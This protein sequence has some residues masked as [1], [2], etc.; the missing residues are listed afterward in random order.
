MKLYNDSIRYRSA[1]FW[2]E[3]FSDYRYYVPAD[4]CTFWREYIWNIIYKSFILTIL[5]YFLLGAV[6]D[7]YIV[8]RHLSFNA[9]LLP[10]DLYITDLL[11]ILG[12]FVWLM[13]GCL[14]AVLTLIAVLSGIGWCFKRVFLGATQKFSETAAGEY[15][16]GKL[17]DFC[18]RI[19]FVDEPRFKPI[20]GGAP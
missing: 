3:L 6:T 20:E 16:E 11:F 9:L 8:I 4:G 13:I 18:P 10:K 19:E 7:A 1:K 12:G 14:A 2:R 17:H 15:I 5:G